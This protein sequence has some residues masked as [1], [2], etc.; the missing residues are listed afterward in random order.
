[1]GAGSSVLAEVGYFADC[2]PAEL[3]RIVDVA[4]GGIELV[5]SPAGTK[6]V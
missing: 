5:V 6:S 4:G 1:M 3:L 2:F